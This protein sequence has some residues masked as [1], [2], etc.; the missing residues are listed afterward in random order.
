MALKSDRGLMHKVVIT[1][2]RPGLRAGLIAGSVALLA[3]G[4]WVLYAYARATTVSDF[5][6]AQTERD[7][8]LTER[9]QLTR[10]L[11]AAR[12]EIATLRGETVYLQR[13]QEI[14]KQSSE[15]VKGSL[16]SL[17]KEL[18]DLREQV[19]FYR[20]I[21]SPDASQ[22]GVRVYEFKVRPGARVG[23]YRYDLVLIQ[24]VRHDR[25][26]TGH[27]EVLLSGSGAGSS[28]RLS[29][30]VPA[31]SL[32]FSFKYF[33]EFTGEFRLPTG[34]VPSRVLVQVLPEGGQ[35]IEDDFDWAKI[36]TNTPKQE[37]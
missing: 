10:D 32:D 33:Q 28:L 30:L 7:Q 22:A 19:A 9:R 36:Q 6:R 18:A 2:H 23:S 15:S 31:P 11:R 1:P 14:D 21:V 27:V 16:T 29:D 8:L 13:S 3:L 37:P 35:K 34:F 20:G 26:I 5:E 4:A 12:A 17:Q 25:R 24:S